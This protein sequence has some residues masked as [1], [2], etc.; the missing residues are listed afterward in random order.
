MNQAET[1]KRIDENTEWDWPL[2]DLKEVLK[3]ASSIADDPCPYIL[4]TDD[5]IWSAN[6]YMM[7]RISC[8]NPYGRIVFDRRE[9]RDLVRFLSPAKKGKEDFRAT[10]TPIRHESGISSWIRFMFDGQERIV[11]NRI[12]TFL[13]DFEKTYKLFREDAKTW[14]DGEFFRIPGRILER[15]GKLFSEESVRMFFF[16][17]EEN[18]MIWISGEIAGRRCDLICDIE[19]EN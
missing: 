15:A 8:F 2:R 5:G 17:S 6:N 11:S 10:M 12:A 3:A 13:P 16:Q 9:T 1:E 19:K 7:I 14:K 18:P 4:F